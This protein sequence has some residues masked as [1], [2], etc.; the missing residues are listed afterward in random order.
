[1]ID[2]IAPHK[3]V[4]PSCPRQAAWRSGQ[5]FLTNSTRIIENF[6]WNPGREVSNVAQLAHRR[7]AQGRRPRPRDRAGSICRPRDAGQCRR[8]GRA[9]GTGRP[10]GSRAACARRAT[11][12]ASPVPG[13]LESLRSYQVTAHKPGAEQACVGFSAFTAR[14]QATSTSAGTPA[15]AAAGS[16]KS[17]R[18]GPDAGQGQAVSCHLSLLA[19]AGMAL[20][21]DQDR[22]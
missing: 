10:H 1:M 15:G 21:G 14:V 12:A 2:A 19:R 3:A 7:H 11:A 17:D 20:S 16:G 6:T 4:S 13:V 9:D 18:F 22:R 8:G 5:V